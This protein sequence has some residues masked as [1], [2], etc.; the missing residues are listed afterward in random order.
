MFNMVL[1]IVETDYAAHNDDSLP[2]AEVVGW[3]IF[4]T[5]SVFS[6]LGLLLGDVFPVSTLRVFRLCKLARV[7]KVF[8]VFP[9][10]RL[11]MAGLLGSFRAIFWG[12]VLLAFVL[13]VW[14][15][16][17]V[18]FIHPLNLDLAERGVLENCDRCP[19]A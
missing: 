5:D 13:L 6:V 11:M 1:I 16:V 10:L 15:I 19:R 17:A 9:E 18:Q 7:S 12:T 8:R 14:A 4:M 3:V 2:W